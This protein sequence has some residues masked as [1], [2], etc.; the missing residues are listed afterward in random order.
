MLTVPMILHRATR[1]R[2]YPTP[3]QEVRLVAWQRAL[4]SLWNVAHEQRLLGLA[5][6]RVI[7]VH[8]T[9]SDGSGK[10]YSAGVDERVF[11]KYLAQQAELTHLRAD[12]PWLNDVPCCACQG[13]LR[14]LDKAW[15]RCF[16]GLASTPKW[17]SRRGPQPN[18][19]CGA[20]GS[21]RVENNAVVFPKLGAIRA[22][23]H[24]P[25]SGAVKTMQIV[26]D[27][28]Q[29]FAV[30]LCEVEIAN[31]APHAGPA[32]GID[33]GVV[34]VLADSDGRIVQNFSRDS[35]GGTA[36]GG[37]GTGRPS[38]QEERA[39]RPALNT[40]APA[41]R[42]CAG[43]EALHLVDVDLPGLAHP[44]AGE[45]AKEALP[46]ETR[47]LRLERSIARKVEVAKAE[48]RRPNGKN[49]DKA[50]AKLAKLQRQ[51]RRQR[52]HLLHAESKHYAEQYG[53]IVLE[54]LHT[55]SMMA[56]AKGT[57]EEPGVNV[58]QKAG[59]NRGIASAGWAKFATLVT[60][61]SAER[62]G[63]VVEVPAAYSSQ[64]CSGCGH[65][66]SE[67]RPTQARFECQNCGLVEHA[68]VNAAKVI[69]ARGLAGQTVAPKAPKKT[70][71]VLR[72]KP[73]VPAT[74]AVPAVEACGGDPIGDPETPATGQRQE[75]SVAR[76]G[77]VCMSETSAPYS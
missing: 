34:N 3:E 59:L 68:D 38:K 23:I 7:G 35:S 52:D 26:C 41:A 71:R 43:E 75:R 49:I 61:K 11:V 47:R 12:L 62:G 14:D 24:R 33:R 66:A 36:C 60:Y 13:I 16:K 30:V 17:K 5:R 20:P 46:M 77:T 69:L 54:K 22:V 64:T 40:H 28:D 65:V 42:P 74:A 51:G 1:Y 55:K 4:R 57:V 27:V 56:S 32:V 2:I 18:L 70:L 53:T 48:H 37:S 21:F 8:P 19:F 44:C 10:S 72:R 9:A 45:E 67:N 31:P 58:A 50:R 15:D 6:H 29:W 73:K 39:A 63:R 76:R 25:P